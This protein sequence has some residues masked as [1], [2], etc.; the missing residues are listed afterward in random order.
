MDE[1]QLSVLVGRTTVPIVSG[2]NDFRQNNSTKREN[3]GFCVFPRAKPEAKK[4]SSATCV[5]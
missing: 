4:E 2:I 1:I 5:Q 3:P